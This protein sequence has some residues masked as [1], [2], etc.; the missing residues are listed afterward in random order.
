MSG[1]II[2]EIKEINDCLKTK[3]GLTCAYL[4]IKDT[5]SD[6]C[7]VAHTMYYVF[8]KMWIEELGKGNVLIL[9]SSE[10]F[11]NRDI[12]LTKIFQFLGL[13]ELEQKEKYSLDKMG[14]Q[15]KIKHSAELTAIAQKDLENFVEPWEDLLADYLQD[16]SFRWHKN[17]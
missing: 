7:H 15:N 17:K 13:P 16:D 9:N 12:S 3:D 2:K 4:L 5:Q 14:V 1:A 8:V 11:R 6:Y 10:Y